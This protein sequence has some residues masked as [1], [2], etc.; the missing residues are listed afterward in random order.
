VI[1]DVPEPPAAT[2][3]LLA[4]KLKLLADTPPTITEIVPLELA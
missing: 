3:A 1:V 2:V 4:I